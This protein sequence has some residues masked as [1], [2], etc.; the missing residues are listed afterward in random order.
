MLL[1]KAQL[2][3]FWRTWSATCAVQGWTRDEGWTTAQIDDKRHELLESLGFRSLK[4]VDN[5]GFD[6]VLA[7]LRSL[8]DQVR[9]AVDEVRPQNGD[10]RRLLWRIEW[11]AK[12][13]ELYLPGRSEAYIA[14]VVADKF[15]AEDKYGT[16]VL[17]PRHWRDLSAVR[18]PGKEDSELDQ[19]RM[20]L[21]ARLNGRTGMRVK[22]G[23]SVHDMCSRAGVTCACEA[24][25]EVRAAQ[26]RA[27]AAAPVHRAR[28][29]ISRP[30]PTPVV[31]GGGEED[32]NNP[33]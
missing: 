23:E 21:T 6:K 11:L 12:C 20:T 25:K 7:R 19:L 10:A 30:A 15:P 1:S 3:L 27:R 13:I 5:R 14:E 32:N 2:T 18:S 33:F 17:H 24:C 28:K 26:S 22:H 31:A 16:G 8:A 9:G 4:D 29:P